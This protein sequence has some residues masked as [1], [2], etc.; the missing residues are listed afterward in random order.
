MAPAPTARARELREFE[1]AQAS[2]KARYHSRHGASDPFV[3]LFRLPLMAKL[4]LVAAAGAVAIGWAS[5]ARRR[6]RRDPEGLP[7]GRGPAN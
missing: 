3:M 2:A 1:E 7:A 6:A 5:L 4:G